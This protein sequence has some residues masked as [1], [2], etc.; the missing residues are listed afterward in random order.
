MPPVRLRWALAW[1][2]S[3]LRPDAFM[4]MDA[5]LWTEAVELRTAYDEGL[6]QGVEEAEM[7]ERVRAR[8]E[9]MAR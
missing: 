8:A 9:A 7:R 4:A 5:Q 6:E 2:L 1:D 3:P